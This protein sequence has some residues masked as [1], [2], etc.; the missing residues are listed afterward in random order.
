MRK[1]YYPLITCIAILGSLL[2]T[3]STHPQDLTNVNE[4][5][6]KANHSAYYQGKDGKAVVKMTIK[7]AQGR[8]RTREL[9]ILRKNM[10]DKDE[11]QRFYVYFHQ[12]AD[13]RDTVFMVHKYVG[14]DD[15]RWLYLPALDVVKRIAASDERT[16]F[17]GSH[18]FYEDVS[19]RGIDE[20]NHE[21]IE[22]TQNFYVLKNTPKNPQNV[23]FDS[24]KVY[25]HKGTFLPIKAEYEK[26]GKVYRVMEALEVKEIQGYPTVIKAKMT[27]TNIGGETLLEY[28]EV[29]YDIGLPDEVFTER[30]LR[31]PPREYLK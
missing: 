16:S 20:D 3:R 29:K 12:P 13:V 11:E 18:F 27:D 4:I 21:L 7:D 6:K 10:D 22:T 1:L 15:D 25:I 9:T 23:E 2:F 19:G 5:V 14:K 17:V 31:K 30:F 28:S 8:E 26:N 24:Y